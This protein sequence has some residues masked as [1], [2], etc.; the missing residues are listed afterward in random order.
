ML[1]PPADVRDLGA[2]MVLVLLIH[3]RA[4]QHP[5][6]QPAH[7]LGGEEIRH[8]HVG[9]VHEHLPRAALDAIA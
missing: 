6:L 5:L 2:A 3:Q 4:R 9:V 1:D 8:R 7:Q